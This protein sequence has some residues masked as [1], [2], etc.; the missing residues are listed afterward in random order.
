MVDRLGRA[1][2]VTVIAAAC[3]AGVSA[4]ETPSAQPGADDRLPWKIVMVSEKEP[5]EPLIVS[6]RI[7]AAD[8]VTP[9]AGMILDVYHTDTEGY[10]S[11]TPTGGADPKPRIVGRLRTGPDGRY[12]LRTIKPGSYPGSRV[13]A[14]IHARVWGPGH[15]ERWIEEFW[16]EGDPFIPAA[17]VQAAL[18]QGALSPIMRVRKGEDGVL[19]CERDIKL[20]G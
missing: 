16:F 2:L 6:G 15:P 3:A 7:L 12:E 14:H 8:G 5:G 11:R 18:S 19:R 13:P 4:Q 10:Y 1:G 9:L 17:Q 20:D